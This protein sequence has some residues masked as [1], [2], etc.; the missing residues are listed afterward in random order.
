[1]GVPLCCPGSSQTPGPKGSSYFM[2]L[3]CWDYKHEP[4]LYMFSY[5]KIFL[6]FV[7]GRDSEVF[8]SAVNP[9]VLKSESQLSS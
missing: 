8:M 3:K 1:M 7:I 6:Y 2:R 9:H 5:K 4:F